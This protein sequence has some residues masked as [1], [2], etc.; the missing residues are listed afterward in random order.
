MADTDRIEILSA[1]ELGLTLARLASQVLESAEDSRK[2]ILLGIPTRGVQLSK[3]L[4]RELE[5]LTGHAIAQGSIDP[6]FHRDDL[7]RIGTRLPQLTTLPT[8]IEDRLVILVDDVI[9]TGRTVRAAL[10][11][12]Q[13]WG[14]PQRVMLLAMVDRGHRE[15]PIQPDFCGR[16]VPTR[17]SES[18][19]L[20]LQDVDGEEGVFLNRASRSF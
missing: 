1:R 2:L 17:R 12:L 14:R 8:S 16:V 6:T 10:E 3:V 4:A 7:E 20:R 11:A 5:R 19:E 9:F 15:L 13:S 18:I